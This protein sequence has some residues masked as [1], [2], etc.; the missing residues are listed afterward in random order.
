MG[1]RVG[2]LNRTCG[3]CSNVFVNDKPASF[4][5]DDQAIAVEDFEY[6][7]HEE[8]SKVK[9]G[10][11]NQLLSLNRYSD[12]LNQVNVFVSFAPFCG[13]SIPRYP[14]SQPTY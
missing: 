9:K 1:E 2:V 12:T 8:A 5:L 4:N 7:S 10:S 13:I 6:G 3:M 11:K 14:G